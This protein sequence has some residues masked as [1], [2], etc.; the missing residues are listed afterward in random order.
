VNDLE[1]RLTDLFARTAAGVEVRPDL[2]RVLD[3]DSRVPARSR[4]LR[5]GRRAPLAGAAALGVAAAVAATWLV[6]RDDHDTSVAT[7]T[8]PVAEDGN[9]DGAPAAGVPRYLVTEPGW[10]VTGIEEYQPDSGEMYFEG[11]GGRHAELSWYDDDEWESRRDDAGLGGATPTVAIAGHDALVTVDPEPVALWQAGGHMFVL[12]AGSTASLDDLV[13]FTTTF[14]DEV[15]QDEWL[16]ALPDDIVVPTERADLV[17]ATLAQLPVPDGFDPRPH[18]DSE[19]A[20]GTTAVVRAEVAT[21]V[22]CAWIDRWEAGDAAVRAAAT[23]ALGT[24]RDWPVGDYVHS[25]WGSYMGQ[26]AAAM[27]ADQPVN[28]DTSVPP[29]TTYRRAIGCPEG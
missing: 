5:T 26:V 16:A 25:Q 24:W 15:G 9:E 1:D 19:L 6:V 3:D 2:A 13:L 20:R 23:E 11:P 22:A 17:A 4:P 7:G 29:A 10:E 27:A 21:A 14:V 8:P 12:Q 28:G 18:T